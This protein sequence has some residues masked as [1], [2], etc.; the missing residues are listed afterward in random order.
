MKA[1]MDRGIKI[2]PPS[3]EGRLEGEA[4]R[5]CPEG[6]RHEV[7]KLGETKEKVSKEARLL[8][9]VD[10]AGIVES[11]IMRRTIGGRM[12]EN[13]CAAKVQTTS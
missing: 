6:A 7:A 9:S 4:C 13:V 11:Q 10:P 2:C 5:E 3:F 12:K 1:V 8:H